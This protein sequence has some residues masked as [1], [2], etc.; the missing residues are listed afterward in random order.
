MISSRLHG[1]ID[2]GVAASLGSASASGSLSPP[3]RTT[4]GAAGA[5]HASY[6]AVTDYGAGLR[7]WLTMP[8]HLALDAI[9]GTALLAIGLMMRRATT[10]ERA[11]LVVVGLSELAV[12]A[13]SD[14]TVASGPS[15]DQPATYPPLDT[16]RPVAHDVFIVESALGGLLGKVLPA[17][18]TVI[19][20]ASGDLLLHSPTRF[21]EGLKRELQAL[22]RVT[23]LVAPNM[24]HWTFL[25]DWQRAYPNAITWAAPGL[26]ERS[27]V[28]NS[29]IQIDFVLGETAPYAWGDAITLVMVPGGMKFHEA[30]LFH[31]PSRTLVLTDLVL[32]LEPA[33]LPVL[34]R[35]IVELFGS[36]APDGMPP[37]YLRAL[38]K[39]RRRSASHAASR[40]LDLRPERVI[41]AHGRWFETNG[42]EALR[43]SLRWLVR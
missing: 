17:R 21:T 7:P 6:A 1:L 36:T 12:V 28:R 37:P 27:Q 9:G 13:L 39:L 35:P 38:I 42:T 22:G 25:G 24:A 4:L 30:A 26:R 14:T 41:F 2:W 11:L 15:R 32:N 34:L 16:P 20:L 5:Y 10:A 29:G 40:L 43:R 19:R 18:M 23:H 33:K 3:V 8:Q 31:R